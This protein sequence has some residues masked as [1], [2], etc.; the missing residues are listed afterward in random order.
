MGNLG[1]NLDGWKLILAILGIYTRWPIDS[2]RRACGHI[3]REVSKRTLLLPFALAHKLGRQSLSVQKAAA[4]GRVKKG[5]RGTVA[6]RFSTLGDHTRLDDCLA[7]ILS[8]RLGC[9]DTGVTKEVQVGGRVGEPGHLADGRSPS[10]VSD[11][12]DLEA[13]LG[14]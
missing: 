11:R 4:L 12:V 7:R 1:L 8:N 5:R 6:E 13:R 10:H 9:D 2:S 14:R 3:A